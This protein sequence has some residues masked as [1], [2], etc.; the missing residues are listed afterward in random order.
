MNRYFEEYLDMSQTG[1]IEYLKFIIEDN[2]FTFYDKSDRNYG[3]RG[4]QDAFDT[5]EERDLE[6]NEYTILYSNHYNYTKKANDDWVSLPSQRRRDR[7]MDL[8][9]GL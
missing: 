7:Q 8:P 3:Y 9:F 2:Y 5:I 4:A 1:R 6:G